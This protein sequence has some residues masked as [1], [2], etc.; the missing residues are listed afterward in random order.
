MPD[1]NTKDVRHITAYAI[2]ESIDLNNRRIRFVISS[3]KLDR[4]RERVEV[5]AVA[6]AIPAFAANPVFMAAHMHRAMDAHPTVIGSWDTDSFKALAHHSEMDAVFGTTDLAEQ[7]WKNYSSRHQRAVSIGFIPLEGHEEV[8]E[9]FG[10]IFVITKLELIEI[11]AVAVGSNR[12]AL[13]KSFLEDPDFKCSFEAAVKLAVEGEMK[14]V[15]A[16]VEQH[17]DEIKML[18]TGAAGYADHLLSDDPELPGPD[19][20]SEDDSNVLEKILE[21]VTTVKNEKE[22]THG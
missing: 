6:G 21:S 13:A 14:K 12:E 7:Y 15:S 2:K 11:S 16:A 4:D 3:D 19:G 18:I 1:Y 10:R 22:S 17:F 20:K 9:K 8:S 5:N